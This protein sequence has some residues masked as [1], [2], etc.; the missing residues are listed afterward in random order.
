LSDD[1]ETGFRETRDFLE[2]YDEDP[3]VMELLRKNWRAQLRRKDLTASERA[4]IVRFLTSTD[5][6][7]PELN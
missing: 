6:H 2:K 3:Q 4:A 5:K 7:K 1:F